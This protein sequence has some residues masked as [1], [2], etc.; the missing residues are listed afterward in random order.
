MPCCAIQK[1][2]TEYRNDSE[3]TRDPAL[4]SGNFRAMETVR[5]VNM[6]GEIILE[7][8]VEPTEENTDFA[9]ASTELSHSIHPHPGKVVRI[10]GVQRMVQRMVVE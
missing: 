1:S 7:S 10:T 9:S 3:T 5:V 8:T 6:A 4:F 2:V